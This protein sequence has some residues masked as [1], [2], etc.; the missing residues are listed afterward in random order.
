MKY[1]YIKKEVF[2]TTFDDLSS[3]DYVFTDVTELNRLE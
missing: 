1:K 3:C 2:I